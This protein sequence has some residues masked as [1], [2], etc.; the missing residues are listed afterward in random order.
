M[1]PKFKDKEIKTIILFFLKMQI[2]KG[3]DIVFDEEIFEWTKQELELTEEQTKNALSELS[4][5][6]EIYQPRHNCY[7]PTS[8]VI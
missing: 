2:S 7:K 3:K 4:K 6:G 1:N 8:M 5:M